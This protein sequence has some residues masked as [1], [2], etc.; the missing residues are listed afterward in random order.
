MPRIRIVL[1]RKRLLQAS[2]CSSEDTDLEM[3]GK[4]GQ[5]SAIANNS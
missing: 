3:F 2:K 4:T 5:L 1:G